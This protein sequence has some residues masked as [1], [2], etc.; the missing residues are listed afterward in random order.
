MTDYFILTP[1]SIFGAVIGIFAGITLARHM[2]TTWFCN[3]I[4]SAFMRG[5]KI[6][7]FGLVAVLVI[8]CQSNRPASIQQTCRMEPEIQVRAKKDSHRSKPY[9]NII[10]LGSIGHG[11]T[12]LTAAA[13]KV[14]ADKYGGAFSRPER[15]RNPCT[16][17]WIGKPARICNPCNTP[18]PGVIDF[19]AAHVEYESPKRHYNHFDFPGHEDYMKNLIIGVV[20]IDAAVLIVSNHQGVTAPVRKQL[21]LAQQTGLKQ[22]VVFLDVAQ[23]K[24][25]LKDL[26]VLKN[27]I[28]TL[29]DLQGFGG[30]ETPI[31]VGSASRALAGDISAFGRHSIERLIFAM[32]DYILDPKQSSDHSFLMAI[33]DVIANTG[34]GVTLMGRIERGMLQKGDPIE[35]I[36]FGDKIQAR[37]T[38]I[39]KL[40]MPIISEPINSDFITLYFGNE[41][42]LHE[43][44][45]VDEAIPDDYVVVFF[46]NETGKFL[47][48]KNGHI[49]TQIGS[50][51]QHIRFESE[52]YMFSKEERGCHNS[53]V[54]GY[55]PKFHFGTTT[56]VTGSIEILDGVDKVAPGNS[57][58]ISINLIE[59]MAMEKGMRFVIRDSGRTIGHGVVSKIIDS[60]NLE[61][62]PI[63]II[64]PQKPKN[65]DMLGS[66]VETVNRQQGEIKWF[67]E[68]KGFGFI[69]PDDGNADDVF[70]HEKDIIAD[71]FPQ[72][73]EGQKVSY[74]IIDLKGPQAVKV[75][76]NGPMK[77][78]VRSLTIAD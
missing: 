22:V 30:T 60:E 51:K 18:W 21:S 33:E 9:L 27:E 5:A 11:K 78:R 66:I 12:L 13:D 35:F 46:A 14:M 23:A 20:K 58:K 59:P 63:N 37:A 48:V 2:A 65:N 38:E 55:S 73:A 69:V 1:V 70:V 57:V 53:F 32:D 75:L 40:P 67:N 62:L 3:M 54:N 43:A 8:S 17:T 50:I 47:Q 56:G 64:E 24:P 41:T 72:L 71:C 42:Q 4:K 6:A 10:S 36:G 49:L 52:V 28:R 15:I 31:I 7:L 34:V 29:L 76:I 39:S 19:K 26:Q 61:N 68:Y 74:E 16:A 44:I 45:R 77:N 25:N